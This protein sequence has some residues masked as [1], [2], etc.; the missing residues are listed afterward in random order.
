MKI[1]V[2]GTGYVGLVTA[3]CFANAGHD[4]L[5]LDIDK[6]KIS[7]LKKGICPIFEPNLEGLLKTALKKGNIQFTTKKRLSANHGLFQ[8]L[9]VGTPQLK[10][11]SPNLK[12]IE[13]AAKDIAS[14]MF[15]F[16]T[17]FFP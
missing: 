15:V 2:I 13:A 1:S 9:C 6:K 3:V 5:C 7:K 10:N 8:F 4:V 14:N 16:P 17:P 12:Y 11:G